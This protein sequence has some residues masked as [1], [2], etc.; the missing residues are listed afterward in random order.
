MVLALVVAAELHGRSQSPAG[1]TAEGEE[2]VAPYEED[3]ESVSL[4]VEALEAVE[5]D[6]VD[7][8]AI[9]PKE[10]AYG[11][12]EGM[13]DSLGDEGHTRFLTPEEVE[14]TH[15]VISNKHVVGIGVKLEDKGDEIVVSAG[16]SADEVGIEPGDV[17][18]AVN[19]ES[20][21]G[22]NIVE[23][24]EKLEGPEGPGWI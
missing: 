20:V 22:E 1:T 4:Y 19:G 15:K 21:Q 7:Q 14:E 17:L 23:M 6:Y 11:A 10:Q 9:D 8:E 2:S 16:S 13:L 18:V 24:T 12:I 3:R 5:E